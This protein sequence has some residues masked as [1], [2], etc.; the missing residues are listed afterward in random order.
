S[1]EPTQ[2][3]SS[4]ATDISVMPSFHARPSDACTPLASDLAAAALPISSIG[5]LFGLFTSNKLL[6]PD[7]PPERHSAASVS[8]ATVPKRRGTSDFG[9]FVIMTA[10]SISQSPGSE[11]KADR[12]REPARQRETERVDPFAE[13]VVDAIEIKPAGRAVAAAPPEL[14]QLG[15]DARVG[16][17]QREVSH[18]GLQRHVAQAQ[19]P[20]GP[21]RRHIVCQAQLPPAQE[22]PVFVLVQAV[23]RRECLQ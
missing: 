2:R 8:I 13:V 23:I 14:V 11:A 16:G 20:T 1:R 5:T 10:I 19:F 15:I 12:E 4:L 6:H 3:S 18:G 22:L 9:P 7:T 21:L 17:P